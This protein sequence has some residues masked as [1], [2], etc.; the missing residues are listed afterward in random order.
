MTVEE[1][2]LNISYEIIKKWNKGDYVEMFHFLH[3]D[4]AFECPFVKLVYPENEEKFIK[5]NE[6]VVKYW[7]DVNE[8]L[9]N[10]TFTIFDTEI[11]GKNVLLKCTIEDRTEI[12][13]LHIQ[14]DYYGKV[15]NMLAEYY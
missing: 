1:Q 12:L 9:D 5:G 6:Q 10:K 11:K 14:F 8:V 15:I 4:I 3:Q 2:L 13:H 7:I